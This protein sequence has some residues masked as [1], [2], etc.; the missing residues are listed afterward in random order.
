MDLKIVQGTN[1]AWFIYDGNKVKLGS[2]DK[3]LIED[4]FKYLTGEKKFTKDDL[5]K[6]TLWAQ[7]RI[8]EEFKHCNNFETYYKYAH[9]S[10]SQHE[11]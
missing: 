1:E 5:L 3:D 8:P 6:A 7:F 11:R 10:K 9:G 2:H 4:I